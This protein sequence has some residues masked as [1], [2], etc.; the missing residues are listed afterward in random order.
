MPIAKELAKHIP[1]VVGTQGAIDDEAAIAFSRDFY[2]GI[3][4]GRSV[5][6]A[7]KNGIIGIKRE[8]RP[9]ADIPV[10]VRGVFAD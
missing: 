4:K 6:V 3:I 1:Y 9:G 10:L 5:E 2:M 8:K 7:F